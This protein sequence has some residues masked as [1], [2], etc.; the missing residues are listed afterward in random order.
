MKFRETCKCG[1][2]EHKYTNNPQCDLYT[3]KN[4]NKNNFCKS[5]RL[6]THLRK[7]SKLCPFYKVI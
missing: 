5:C 6:T 2:S 4:R 3:K 7:S 1:S